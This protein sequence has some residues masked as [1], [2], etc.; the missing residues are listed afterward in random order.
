[1]RK[2]L[3]ILGL[4]GAIIFGV[5][6]CGNA[7]ADDRPTSSNLVGEWYQTS[8]GIEGYVFYASVYKSSIQVWMSPREESAAAYWMGTFDTASRNETIVSHGDPDATYLSLDHVKRFEYDHGDLMFRF[9]IMGMVTTVHMSRHMS[10]TVTPTPTRTIYAPS[11]TKTRT[12]TPQRTIKPP[13]VK[14]PAA[15]ATKKTLK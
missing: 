1:M 12:P 4:L 3:L 14:V 8:S 7:D 15:P 11:G 6:A 13:T 9:E 10:H 5:S 2:V